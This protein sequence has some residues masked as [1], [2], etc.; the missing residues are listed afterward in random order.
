MEVN[1]AVTNLKEYN[2]RKLNYI[3]VELGVVSNEELE[4][5]ITD[6]FGKDVE[7]FFISDFT[8]PF[9]IGEYDNFYDLNERL[10]NLS[11][12]LDKI[13]EDVFVTIH[14]G[15]GLSFDETVELIRNQE[16]RIYDVSTSDPETAMREIAEE[17][18]ED[19]YLGTI[20]ER[21]QSFINYDSVANEIQTT[22]SLSPVEGKYKYVELFR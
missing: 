7:E 22:C 10:L 2:E 6:H 21:L 1:V 8:S 17:K 12:S 5:Q 4:V 11:V 18:V 13:D 20:P 9:E 14:K 15:F 19:G 16:Y 3:W